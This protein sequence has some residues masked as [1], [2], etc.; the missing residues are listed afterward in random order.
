MLTPGTDDAA[1]LRVAAA[2][3]AAGIAVAIGDVAD[4]AG[5]DIRRARVI[6]EAHVE[7][8]GVARAIEAAIAVLTG[9]RPR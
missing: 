7:Y 4:G 6:D 1:T 3:R 5:Q 2:M 9:G 8:E